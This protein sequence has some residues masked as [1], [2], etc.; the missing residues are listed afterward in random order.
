MLTAVGPQQGRIQ[1]SGS[2]PWGRFAWFTMRGTRDEGIL[3]IS[4]Y[5]VSQA[6]GTKSGPMTAYSQQ[7][8][9]MIKEGDLNLDPRTRLLDD[10][11]SLITDWRKKGFR[12]ILMMDAN[13]DLTNP[14]GS[15]FQTFV[16]EMGLIDPLTQKFGDKVV[17]TT[18]SRGNRRIDFILTDATIAQAVRRVG[19]LGLHEGIASDHVMLYLDCDEK[20][21]FKRVIN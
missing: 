2:D 14:K 20:T 15:G 5:R 1:N 21:I 7:I 17:S 11:R 9:E 12:P 6:K 4:A 19:T 3:V 18:Y 13:D 8:N 10:L 16:T